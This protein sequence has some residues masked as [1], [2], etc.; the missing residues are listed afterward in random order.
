MCQKRGRAAV[1]LP[2]Q[3]FAVKK[4]PALSNPTELGKSKGPL[5]ETSPLSHA[6]CPNVHVTGGICQGNT[7]FPNCSPQTIQQAC[8]LFLEGSL[9]YA[10]L[11][12]GKCHS[13]P[14]DV[15]VLWAELDGRKRFPVSELM[16]TQ[17]SIRSLL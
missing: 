16:P 13:Y 8:Q 1:G 5:S 2:G 7:P 12:R 15:R 9:F 4:R 11:S 3:I 10:D 17:R 14:E 6:P